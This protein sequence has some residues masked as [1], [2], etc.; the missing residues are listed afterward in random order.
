VSYKTTDAPIELGQTAEWFRT[1][2]HP[3]RLKM[4]QLVLRG[5]H[6]VGDLADACGIPS[7]QASEHLSLMRRCGL[8]KSEHNGRK[9]Y[10]RVAQPALKEVMCCLERVLVDGT[11]YPAG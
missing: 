10:Y 6:S 4:I 8:L 3:H 2:G 1:I 9:V 5:G 7:H 11:R